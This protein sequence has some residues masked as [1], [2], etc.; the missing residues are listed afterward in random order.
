ML[1]AAESI[2]GESCEGQD[3]SW[4]QIE[5]AAKEVREWLELKLTSGSCSTSLVYQLAGHYCRMPQFFGNRVLLVDI[6]AVFD[7]IGQLEKS[8]LTRTVPTKPATMF[9]KGPLKGLWHKHWFQADFLPTNLLNE[10]IK[11]GKKLM[12]KRLNEIFG[13]NAWVGKSMS[14]P[15]A[16]Q[17]ADSMVN[18][19]LAHRSGT[20][21][22]KPSRLTGEWIIFAKSRGRNIYLTLAGHEEA[23]DSIFSRCSL[24]PKE[25]PELASAAPFAINPNASSP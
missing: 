19:A 9:T 3:V 8:K 13:P 16:A 7:Q 14:E 1:P 17:L 22:K 25:Y 4:A 23:N 5:A 11:N 12:M 20:A 6:H 10:S 15:L 24:A 2:I 18:G 21:A